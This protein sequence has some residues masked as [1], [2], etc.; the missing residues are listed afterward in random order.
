MKHGIYDLQRLSP[1]TQ[2]PA[3]EASSYALRLAGGV[4]REDGKHSAKAGLGQ[5]VI[6]ATSGGDLI[7][8]DRA[9]LFYWPVGSAK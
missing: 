7:A 3:L 5:N 6:S 4:R 9:P 8:F 2:R 1:C